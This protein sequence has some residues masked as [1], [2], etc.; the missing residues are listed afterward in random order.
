MKEQIEKFK[1]SLV[2]QLLQAEHKLLELQRETKETKATI[3]QLRG[4][5]FAANTISNMKVS[6][7]P[8]TD[9]KS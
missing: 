4:G 8:K 3:E 1:K 6:D 2:D 5:L 7:A 9:S